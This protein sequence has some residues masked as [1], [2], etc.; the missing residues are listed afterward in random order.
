MNELQQAALEIIMKMRPHPDG[1]TIYPKGTKGEPV[2]R[3]IHRITR[4]RDGGLQIDG[5]AGTQHY[6]YYSIRDAERDYNR[7]ARERTA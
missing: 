5:S 7:R 1:W 3:Y 6:L 4:T 2:K